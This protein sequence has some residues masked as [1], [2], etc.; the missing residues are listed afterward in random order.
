MSQW[1]LWVAFMESEIPKYSLKARR[2]NGFP[3]TER[4]NWLLPLPSRYKFQFHDVTDAAGLHKN[5]LQLLESTLFCQLS[6]FLLP[7]PA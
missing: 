6:A 4:G 2:R 1:A 3:T 7:V 5:M